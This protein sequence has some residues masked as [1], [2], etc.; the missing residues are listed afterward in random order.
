MIEALTRRFPSMTLLFATLA[1]GV[2]GA[3][4]VMVLALASPAKLLVVVIGMLGVLG[5]IVQAEVGLLSLV[6]MTYT[7]FSDILVHY[8]GAPSTAKLFVALLVGSI[9][10]RWIFYGQQPKGWQLSTTLIVIYGLV[11]FSSLIYAADYWRA[12]EAVSDYV[13]DGLI[14]IIITI[15]LQ[16]A[17]TLRRVIWSLLATGIFMGTISAYQYLTSS[18]DN[19]FWGFGQ[20]AVMHIIGESNDFRISGPV[21]DPNFFAQILLVLVPLALDRMW[22]EQQPGLRL[23]AAWAM[24]ASTLT[25]LFTFSRGAFLALMVVLAMTLIR[26][27]PRPIVLFL[28]VAIVF[29]ML[30]FIPAGYTDRLSTLTA[31]LPIIGGGEAKSEVSFRGRTSELTV[32]WL[33]FM[34]NP[35]T[36]VGLDN[37]P[38]HYQRYSRRVGLD[39]RRE[40]RAPHSFYLQI[41][42]ETGLMGLV[43]L[44]GILWI[45][46][47][48]LG[49]AERDFASI[50]MRNSAGL[51]AS[52]TIGVVGYLAGA[53]FLH[54]AYPRYFWLL[55]G[56]G[57]AIPQV[58]KNEVRAAHE[59]EEQEAIAVR[60]QAMNEKMYTLTAPRSP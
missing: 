41:A 7:R 19:N 40:A 27:P 8:H 14:V 42:A 59:L 54:A 35:I 29:P 18:F 55:F 60:K 11:G 37:Y 25:I 39:P 12:Q 4:A 28:T 32:A 20:A 58:A 16:R 52:F 34:D 22:G 43:T 26:R 23:L 36:G 13:K 5:T 21:G 38:V 1:L 24:A 47:R 44:G 17:D 2:G 46:I 51:T 48:R 30:Q 45:M 50:G 57:L 56:I 3:S 15:L 49:Y 33:M 53:V 31:A 9:V 10:L 6:F